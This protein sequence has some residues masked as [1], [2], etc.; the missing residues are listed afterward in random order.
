MAMIVM[1][2]MTVTIATVITGA[3]PHDRA[4]PGW[5]LPPANKHFCQNLRHCTYT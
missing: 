1:I 3:E 4:G 2:V 5:P